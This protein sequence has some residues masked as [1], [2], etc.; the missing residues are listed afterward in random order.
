MSLNIYLS[1]FALSVLVIFKLK[2]SSTNHRLPLPP[3][4]PRRWLVGNLLDLPLERPWETYKAW[5]DK[6]GDIVYFDFP[7]KPM[8]VIGS[9]KVA[10]DLLDARSRIYS[11]RPESVMV[12]MTAWDWAFSIMPYNETWR[13]LR[14]HFHDH[15][16]GPALKSFQPVKLQEVRKM[17]KHILKNPQDIRRHIRNVPG[18]TIIRV[19]Y[20]PHSEAQ[21]QHYINLAEKSLE[22]GKKMSV[23][24]MFFAEAIPLM[25][26]IPSWLPGGYARKFAAEYKPVVEEMVHK[27]YNEVKKATAS[28]K[29]LPSIAYRL[30]RQLQGDAESPTPEQDGVARGVTAMAYVGAVD[31][32]TAAI[33]FACLV[34][35]LYPHVQTKL[36]KEIDA[37]LGCSRLPEFDDLEH[38]TYLKAVVLETLRSFP[39][40]PL[41]VPH[42]VTEDDEYNGFHIPRSTMIFPNQWQVLSMTCVCVCV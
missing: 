12:K 38:L 32:T 29:E 7:S 20:G 25:Q 11:S 37:H 2:T 22:A 3:G 5:T 9:L 41:A 28:G 35:A 19:T 1:L 36:Q 34:L 23:P 42:S 8:I 10:R 16:T 6:Y 4:P 40:T 33:E 18:S 17:L 30:I 27:P 13:T 14:R 26:Y 24:G 39:I 15:Y 31:T 21:T